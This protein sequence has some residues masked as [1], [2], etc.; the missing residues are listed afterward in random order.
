MVNTDSKKMLRHVH[1]CACNRENKGGYNSERLVEKAWDLG[2][3]CEKVVLNQ[4]AKQ[5]E[6]RPKQVFLGL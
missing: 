1:V 5:H 2:K 3:I 4:K 6:G